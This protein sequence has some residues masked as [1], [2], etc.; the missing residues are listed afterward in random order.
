MR[1]RVQGL[2][3]ASLRAP[4]ARPRTSSRL[5]ARLQV[6]GS[7]GLRVVD[8]SVMPAITRGNSYAPSVT[9]GE[10]TAE[11]ILSTA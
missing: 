7:T 1:T 4:A 9:V 8:A 5:S 10:H 6:H 3:Q 11:L 2:H